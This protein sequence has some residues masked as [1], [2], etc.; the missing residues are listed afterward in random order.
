[1]DKLFT[2]QDIG[3]TKR[4]NTAGAALSPIRSGF[5]PNVKI[6]GR[7]KLLFFNAEFRKINS[8][9]SLTGRAPNRPHRSRRKLTAG[10]AQHKTGQFGDSACGETRGH[11]IHI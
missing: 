3:G 1:M 10:P 9:I 8:F 2:T 5:E 7:D 6:N 11:E 4:E